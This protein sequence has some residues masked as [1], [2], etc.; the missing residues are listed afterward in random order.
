M[1]TARLCV[2][3]AVVQV[4]SVAFDRERT[5]EKARALTGDAARQGAQLV[6]FPEA[7]VSGYPRGLSFGAV[8]GSRTPEGRED[9]RRYWQSAVLTGAS[10]PIS[11]SPT[12]S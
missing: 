5:L 9:Y 1:G 4:A 10:G 12:D 2:R 8:V 11:T 6:V 7:F 3:A